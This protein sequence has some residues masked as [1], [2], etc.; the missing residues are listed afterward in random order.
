MN[1]KTW[2]L[3][4]SGF[5]LSGIYLN[6]SFLPYFMHVFFYSSV[7][8]FFVFFVFREDFYG[9]SK[10]GWVISVLYFRSLDDLFML[11]MPYANLISLSFLLALHSAFSLLPVCLFFLIPGL[12]NFQKKEKKNPHLFF[13]NIFV[14][15]FSFHSI[16]LIHN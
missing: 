7:Y 1:S 8:L 14:T 13:V 9:F 11:I 16:E 12:R 10:M 2:D 4:W 5:S 3:T 6:L 15:Q